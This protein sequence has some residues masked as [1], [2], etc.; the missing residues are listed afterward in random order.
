MIC[1]NDFYWKCI[2]REAIW[3]GEHPESLK[4][5]KVPIEEFSQTFKYGLMDITNSDNFNQVFNWENSFFTGKSWKI[6]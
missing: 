2:L 3:V 6:K 1:L 4:L 5:H